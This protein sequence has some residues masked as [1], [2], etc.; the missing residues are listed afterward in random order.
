MPAKTHRTVVRNMGHPASSMSTRDRH[1]ERKNESYFNGD[2]VAERSGMN[3][4]YLQHLREDGTPETY[5]Q[6]F[7]RMIEDRTIVMKGLRE[8]AKVFDELIFDVNTAY[9]EEHGGYAFACSFFEEAY[10]LAVQQIGGEQF[11]I[12][13]VMHADEK[14]IALSEELGR[15]C[16]HYH[17]HVVYVPVVEKEVLWSKRCKEPLLVGTVKE[18]IP[19]ISHSK[20]W[21][22]R[23][24]VERDGRTVIVNSYSLLQDRFFEHMRDA[25][26]VGFERGERGSTTEHLSDLEYKTKMET[27]RAMQR[28]QEADRLQ[29]Q[30][31]ELGE[32]VEK[33]QRQM[34]S[35]DKRLDV[36]KGQF[37][38]FSE[39]ERMVSKPLL[40]SNLQISPADWN[41]VSELAKRGVTAESEIGNLKRD[42]ADARKDA[43][44][45]R[46]R[47]EQLLE[48]VGMFLDAMKHAPMRVM[49]LLSEVLRQPPERAARDRGLQPDLQRRRSRSQGVR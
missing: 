19:Q 35:L 25:G 22:G 27:E 43:G 3:V 8:N 4:H 7:S 5:E 49:E 11:V 2:I 10:R 16:F 45:W 13:A 32:Q 40:G 33:K 18:V 28:E 34:S 15:R 31:T 20:K 37:A 6:T 23:V 38:T 24:P 41:T 12:S 39:I 47:Y 1:N 17:L 42:L 21:P 36:G 46:T 29:E 9:F 30:A 26:Y 14:N 48:R 44:V